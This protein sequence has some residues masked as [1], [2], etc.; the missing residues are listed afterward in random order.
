MA[1]LPSS[2]SIA[3]P[4]WSD[5]NDPGSPPVVCSRVHWTL[6]ENGCRFS[7]FYAFSPDSRPNL[8][9]CTKVLVKKLDIQPGEDGLQAAGVYFR[10]DMTEARGRRHLSTTRL[11]RMK[12]LWGAGAI[13]NP[14][15]LLLR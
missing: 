1:T 6:D 15:L 14:Q 11:P 10:R 7:T 12:L 8:F 3:D 5:A 2:C 9:V 4:L 13:A